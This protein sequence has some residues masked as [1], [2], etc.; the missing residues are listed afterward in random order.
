MRPF[1]LTRLTAAGA[2]VAAILA[3]AGCGGGDG[4]ADQA[5]DAPQAPAATAPLAPAAAVQKVAQTA[6]AES[7]AY[8]FE[9]SGAGMSMKGHGAFTTQPHTAMEMVIDSMS[10]AGE[11][12]EAARAVKGMQTR[13]IGDTMYFRMPSA[14]VRE[15]HLHPLVAEHRAEPGLPQRAGG[16]EAGEAERAHRGDPLRSRSVTLV[17]RRAEPA[18]SVAP[19]SQR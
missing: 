19:S 6:A 12:A 14:G 1:R 4:T 5:A 8:D 9:M 2:A 3:L 18:R 10:A 15:R 13:I 7:S 16:G 17:R 11:S